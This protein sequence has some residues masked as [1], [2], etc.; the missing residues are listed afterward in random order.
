MKIEEKGGKEKVKQAFDKVSKEGAD[1]E[2][3]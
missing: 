3:K 2:K 1:T